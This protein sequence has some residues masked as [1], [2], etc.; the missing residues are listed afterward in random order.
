MDFTFS[1][2]P[3]SSCMNYSVSS[4][5][6]PSV[7]LAVNPTLNHSFFIIFSLLHPFSPSSIQ[8]YSGLLNPPPKKKSALI[9]VELNLLSPTRFKLSERTSSPVFTHFP[10]F[11]SIFCPPTPLNLFLLKSPITS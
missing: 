4:V 6:S 10:F 11:L 2:A 3:F 7:S 8:K 1:S 9:I 5:A